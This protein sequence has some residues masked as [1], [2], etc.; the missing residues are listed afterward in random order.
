MYN[1]DNYTT[2]YTPPAVIVR[3]PSASGS[4]GLLRRHRLGRRLC[5]RRR[6]PCLLLPF[7][8]LPRRNAQRL[9]LFRQRLCLSPA[10]VCTVSAPVGGQKGRCLQLHTQQV[11]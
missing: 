11:S 3:T 4:F 1:I 5:R 10:A 9:G 8:R 2:A 7:R 6:G